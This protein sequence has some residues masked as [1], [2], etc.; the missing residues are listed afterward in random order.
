[1]KF[2]TYYT[3]TLSLIGNWLG[4]KV[5]LDVNKPTTLMGLLWEFQKLSALVSVAVVTALPVALYAYSADI[6]LNWWNKL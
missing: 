3:L 1:M 2:S 4:D 5:N 6:F